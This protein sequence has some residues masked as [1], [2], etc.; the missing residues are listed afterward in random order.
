MSMFH[1]A[2]R[3]SNRGI[4]G[5]RC[6]AVFTFSCSRHAWPAPSHPQCITGFCPNLV[7]GKTETAIVLWSF[8]GRL[9]QGTSTLG[10]AMWHK[11]WKSQTACWIETLWAGTCS[12]CCYGFGSVPALQ[13]SFFILDSTR[14]LAKK[15]GG[16]VAQW[17]GFF[18]NEHVPVHGIRW[19]SW[20]AQTHSIESGWGGWCWLWNFTRLKSA[21]GELTVTTQEALK[22]KHL[23][24]HA[25]S[26][27]GKL[28][29]S[30]VGS[31]S[32]G[33]LSDLNLSWFVFF[34]PV[35]V[36]NCLCLALFGLWC[37]LVLMPHDF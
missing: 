14:H 25:S 37:V 33:V 1:T 18:Q 15:N 35:Y 4:G 2:E 20:L 8:S 5:S 24:P 26:L 36:S 3:N 30:Q 23:L 21:W 19:Y 34:C 29:L 11:S 22:I 17:W 12:R 16:F 10:N 13:K 28:G 32:G 9:R 6:T 7:Y 27:H 31:Q